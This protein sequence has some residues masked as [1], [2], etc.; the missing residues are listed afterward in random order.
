M[1]SIYKKKISFFGKRVYNSV[2][3]KIL[4]KRK[5][6]KMYKLN[7]KETPIFSVLKDVYAARGVIPF[8][9]PGH[10]QGVGVE[11]EFYNF[12]G[13]NPFKIDVTIFEM[14]DGLHNPKSH[15]KRALELTA[16]AY[17]AKESFFCVNGTSGAIQA[18]IMS[19]VRAGD[20]ILV[21]RNTHKSVNAGVILSGAQ[22]VYMEP[23]IDQENGIAH[24]VS[25]ETVERTLKE[26]PDAS[27]VLI[28]N[29]TY[30]GV[31]TDLKKI[32]ELV[33][34]Y[35]IPLLVDEAHGPHLRF[36]NGD[37]PLSAMEAGADA[38]AQST[39]KII[40]AM[41]QGSIL[42][43]Q[44]DRINYGKMRQVLSLLQ[45]TSPSYILLAS[46]DCARKQIALEG[47]ELIASA[48]KKAEYLREEV[49]KV[50]GFRSLGRE[51]LDGKGRFSFDPT[52]IAITARELGLTGYQLE[53]IFVDKYNIQPELSD[54]YNVLLVTT[55]GDTDESIEAVIAAI[56]DISAG[57]KDRDAVPQFK[58]IPA[59]PEMEQIPREA[60][61]SEKTRKRME[62]AIGDISGEFIMAYPP[63]IPI[64]CP[65]ERITEEVIDYIEDLK[66]AG[67]SVQGL[68]D[69]N[70]ENINIIKEDDAIYLHV[71]KMQ[72]FLLGVPFNLGAAVTGT[73]FSID[74]LFGEYPELKNVIEVLEPVREEEN[75]F[76]RKMK[77]VN[78][79]VATSKALK[80]RVSEL[81]SDGLRP[82]V[83]G[84]DHSVS[85]GSISGVLAEK[86][87]G[88]IWIDAHGDMNTSETSPSG[89]IHGMI[90][91]ALMGYGDVKLTR[92]NKGKFLDP[93]KVLLFGSRDLDAGEIKFIEEK[94]VNLITYEE[95]RSIGLEE[96]MEKAKEM[97]E[98]EELH[99]SF[100][101]DVVD[102]EDAPGV[103]VPVAAGFKK[104]EV[105]EI[106]SELFDHYKV[107]SVDLVELNP[108][109]DRDGM[110]VDFVKDI[111]DF[112]DG[113][114][115]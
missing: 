36:A 77:F 111:I 1:V 114:G 103:S 59:I 42:H 64:L 5:G 38:C 21:P 93:K 25:P 23:E 81:V 102:P 105:L 104:D 92:L 31:A 51:V 56:K 66:R 29:P 15:I 60:F 63:G 73:E 74:Y 13:P 108:L 40:G 7:Q 14:V 45:T 11:S 44:G 86:D 2:L 115:N 68:E 107:S 69:S 87:A 10:K 48:V 70:L 33:H 22:P 95:I 94:G 96:A 112:I 12:M 34:S 88:V 97:L 8:H 80:E 30:Y 58:D 50:K 49:N 106:F 24:G 47:K 110:S 62:D 55:I 72:N 61:F 75:L 26:N 57:T 6:Y 37:L 99:I 52:K 35:D 54:F 27:A 53:R 17:G 84:G 19:T 101:L 113:M 46:L 32:V 9:V 16:D 67:L 89:N 78:S 39:H 83:I 20:K 85:L 18:M 4:E 71:E 28:I 76:D 43:V 91:A 90:L 100:D 3:I 109:T 82:I 98:V 79:V 41:T 65:G